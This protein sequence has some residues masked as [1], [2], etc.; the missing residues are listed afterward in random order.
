MT[1][2]LAHGA[3]QFKVNFDQ[4]RTGLWRARLGKDDH[5][6]RRRR[7]RNRRDIRCTCGCGRAATVASPVSMGATRTIRFQR[8]GQLMT[9]S[10]GSRVRSL[11]MHCVRRASIRLGAPLLGQNHHSTHCPR[12]LY[13][14]PRSRARHGAVTPIIPL[15]PRLVA[16]IE[17]RG[18]GKSNSH[19]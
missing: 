16:I 7:Q 10:H 17:A 11:S 5:L 9:V 12:K 19:G 1:A 2:A 8:V 18:S 4:L 13:R 15:N 14:R 6:D 3:T